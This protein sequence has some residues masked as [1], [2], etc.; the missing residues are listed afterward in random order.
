MR[1]AEPAFKLVAEILEKGEERHFKGLQGRYVR[2]GALRDS[3]TQPSA[4]GA[5][6][7]IHGDQLIFGT[8]IFYAKF[9]RKRKKS[10]VLVLKPTERKAAAATILAYV[11]RGT[12]LR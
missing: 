2:T 6:R 10:A 5:I 3:L 11:S 12:R 1:H 8:S 4:N 9:L 7:E